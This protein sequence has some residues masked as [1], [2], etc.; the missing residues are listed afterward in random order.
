MTSSDTLYGILMALAF[1]AGGALYSQNKK[2][3]NQPLPQLLELLLVTSISGIIGA[4]TAYILL[5]PQYFHNL[6]DY[7]AIHEGG[8]V[9]YGGFFSALAALVMF[10]KFKKL[11]FS[12]LADNLVPSLAL[13]HG[14]GRIGCY[15]SNCCYGSKTNFLKVYKL[16]HESFY[17][18]PTQLY[19]SIGLFTLSAIFCILL[20]SEKGVHKKSD[21]NLALMYTAVY[22]AMRFAIEYLR[23]DS[24]GGFYT[25]MN[26]SPSQ[27][28][29]AGCIVAIILFFICKKLV[30]IR[31]CK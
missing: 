28:I 13:G 3:S 2:N 1:L 19:E 4:R 29:A 16:E 20:N 11:N 12:Y 18:H 17:R 31:R 10:C 14:I 27:L 26:F 23:D 15:F 21:G 30:F 8:L 5:F 7:F 25:S 6:R 24:R 9:F 22:S